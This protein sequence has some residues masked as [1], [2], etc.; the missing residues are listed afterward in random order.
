[1]A[2]SIE[3]R[4]EAAV[5]RV[6]LDGTITRFD[7]AAKDATV[8]YLPDIPDESKTF[9]SRVGDWPVPPRGAYEKKARTPLR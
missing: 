4:L 8:H 2:S 9:K 1:M 7:L 6:G 5:V 3:G